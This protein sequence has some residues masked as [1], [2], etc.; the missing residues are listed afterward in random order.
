MD[1]EEIHRYR[2]QAVEMFYHGF[3][4]SCWNVMG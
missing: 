3:N 4:V 1:Q 2:D